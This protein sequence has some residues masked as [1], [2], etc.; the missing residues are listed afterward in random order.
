MYLHDFFGQYMKLSFYYILY[1]LNFL[2]TTL[3][4]ILGTIIDK[5]L[6]FSILHNHFSK[7]HTSDYLF[8]HSILFK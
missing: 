4:K 8:K 1:N 6:L 2:M 5:D 7:A 3:E